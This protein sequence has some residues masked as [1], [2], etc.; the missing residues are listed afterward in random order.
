MKTANPLQAFCSRTPFILASVLLLALT[1]VSACSGQPF[2][3]PTQ[4]VTPSPDPNIVLVEGKIV[5]AHFAVLG[6]PRSG[7]VEEVLAREGEQIAKGGVI[8]RLSGVEQAR[9]A[10]A[11]ADLQLTSAKKSLKDLVENS[12][13]ATAQAELDLARARIA[14]DDAID[15]RDRMGPAS[16]SFQDN[17]Q[18]EYILA[19][20]AL[21]DAED[22]WSYFDDLPEDDP[23]RAMGLR[24]LANC[25]RRFD[26]AVATLNYSKTGPDKY[27]KNEAE[28]MV[29]LQ[30]SRVE[31]AERRYTRRKDGPDPEELELRQ[32]AVWQ[33]EASLE[34][35]R[36]SLDDLELKAPF[37]G[38]VVDIPFKPG[39]V[40]Q[41]VDG[42]IFGDLGAWQVETSDLK[43]LDVV[44]IHPG[45]P[46]TMTV[47]AIPGIVLDGTVKQV[48]M[49]GENRQGDI[50]YKITMDIANPDPRLL[51]N[52]TVKVTLRKVVK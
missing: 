19:K 17:A 38:T 44:G 21:E 48:N 41:P 34:A 30:Q 16:K 11:S 43:E 15:M 13:V 40:A 2:A 29:N 50:V 5:P 52:M 27:Q 47:K 45:M 7:I 10:I 36:A 31:D 20:Q 46:V 37:Y 22:L 42:V 24:N 23:Q 4:T 12:G 26:T 14:L 1:G 6:F 49:L 3:T 25:Q 32:A 51:W 18:A 8:A 35:A 33:A 9:A 28:A 39:Q